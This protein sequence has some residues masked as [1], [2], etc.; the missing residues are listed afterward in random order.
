MLPA[1]V[2]KYQNSWLDELCLTGEI[3]WGRIFPPKRDPERSRPMASLT[4][5]APVSIFL[6]EDIGWLTARSPV[7]DPQTLSSPAQEL[8]E[9]LTARGAM[10]A[11]DLLS[12]TRLLPAQLDDV[13][14]ELI[15]QGFVTADGFGGLR[16]LIA[17]KSSTNGRD[18][19]GLRRG[20]VRTR[21]STSGVGR[22]SLWRTVVDPAVAP[23]TLTEQWAW[24]LL[25]RWGVMFRDLLT[26]EAG[27]PQ[28]WELV[29]IYRRLEARGE[30]RGG[31]FITGVSGEQFALGDTIRTL[32]QLRDEP[33]QQELVVIS[34][35]DPLNLVGIL[36]QH[37]R[38]IS[39]ASNRVAYLNGKPLAALQGGEVLRFTDIPREVEKLLAEK[40][41]LEFME[42]AVVTA[43]V[44]PPEPSPP[45][46]APSAKSDS[47]PR[48][49]KPKRTYP[50]S[51]PRPRIS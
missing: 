16:R 19:H 23:E 18:S 31:R 44:A 27:A 6:R 28:W 42:D 35:A 45:P 7:L 11:A 9:L 3:G 15:T 30:I 41:R 20:A 38:V 10:F 12:A 8:F 47:K 5:V 26:R 22:W 51:I 21:Q 49:R 46:V 24:Q 32:R 1:R 48:D 37:P 39:T 4:R 2:E 43:E 13:L 25:R 14:G 50:T 36:T 40:F 34:A 33:G 17:S 29:Q